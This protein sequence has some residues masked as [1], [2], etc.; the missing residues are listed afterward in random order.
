MSFGPQTSFASS[1]S[2]QVSIC[3]SYSVYS[4]RKCS[5][6]QAVSFTAQCQNFCRSSPG[7]STA[8]PF[9]VP[10]TDGGCSYYCNCSGLGQDEPSPV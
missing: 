2:V 3:P 4:P 10:T 6:R 5:T 8:V 1:T 7:C 9:V